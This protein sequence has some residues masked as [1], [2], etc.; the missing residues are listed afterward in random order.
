MFFKMGHSEY[1]GEEHRSS[2]DRQWNGGERLRRLRAILDVVLFRAAID[3][4]PLRQIAL[5]LPSLGAKL[6]FMLATTAV[7]AIE[8]LHLK[9]CV[10]PRDV[11]LSWTSVLDPQP[12]SAQKLGGEGRTYP[13]CL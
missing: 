9:H 13:H 1:L 6:G 3:A 5:P 4:V 7:R 12:E 11:G 8:S 2:P 10:P